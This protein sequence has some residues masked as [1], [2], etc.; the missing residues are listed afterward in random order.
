MAWSVAGIPAFRV[1][2]LD[3]TRV[4]RKKYPRAACHRASGLFR[5]DLARHVCVRTPGMAR[6]W[7]GLYA[8]LRDLCALRAPRE[9]AR[10]PSRHPRAAVGGRLA[11]GSSLD[12]LD[13]RAGN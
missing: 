6:P 7:R 13:G 8:R 3:G 9:N 10:W 1:V 11:R 12:D 2:R 5:S 4:E